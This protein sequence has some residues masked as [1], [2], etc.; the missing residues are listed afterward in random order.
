MRILGWSIYNES[1]TEEEL[2]AKVAEKDTRA[3][4]QLYSLLA[5]ELTAVAFRYL[6]DEEDVHD[7]L[8]DSFLKIFGQIQSFTYQGKGSVQA[9]T[10]RIVSN[11]CLQLLRARQKLNFIERLEV[12]PDAED[13]PYFEDISVETIRDFIAELP[14]GY[15]AVFNLHVLEERPHKEIAQLLGITEKTSASELHYAK[16]I[17]AKRINQYRKE[18]QDE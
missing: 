14:P 5:D 7:V 17:L 6:A 3:M 16:A 11:E 10:R 13:E 8:Q 9:W 12:M 1:Y 4:K 2:V 18:R 15:R